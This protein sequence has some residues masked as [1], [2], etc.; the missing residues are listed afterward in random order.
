MKY[1]DGSVYEGMWVNNKYHGHGIL[2]HANGTKVEGHFAEGEKVDEPTSTTTFT[3]PGVPKITINSART[4][5]SPS[6]VTYNS[7]KSNNKKTTTATT[8]TTARVG[9]SKR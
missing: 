6:K 7:A 5:G 8:K 1:N 4:G 2:I 3:D 9:V